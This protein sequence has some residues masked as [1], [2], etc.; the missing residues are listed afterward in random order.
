MWTVEISSEGLR[1]SSED[2]HA[3]SNNVY[4]LKTKK[5]IITYLHKS[6]FS[7]VPS[8]YIDAINSGLFTTW[9]GLTEELV[10]K[11]IDKYTATTKVHLQQIRKNI[12]STK[13]P[14]STRN[15]QQTA[16]TTSSTKNMSQQIILS[17]QRLMN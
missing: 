3:Q 12:L 13:L 1:I 2:I 10:Y 8:T 9:P 11:H 14:M 15:P 6:V 17:P 5:D 4:E 7:P 16:M